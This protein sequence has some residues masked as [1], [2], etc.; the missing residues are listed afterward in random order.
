MPSSPF[1]TVIVVLSVWFVL[2]RWIL[3][4]FGIPTCMGGSCCSVAPHSTEI[5]RADA[6]KESVPYSNHEKRD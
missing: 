5:Q 3:P 2:N 1:F 6:A 4:W